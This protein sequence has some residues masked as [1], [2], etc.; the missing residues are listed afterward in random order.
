MQQVLRTKGCRDRVYTV[1]QLP[2]RQFKSSG[3]VRLLSLLRIQY[4]SRCQIFC[5]DISPAVGLEPQIYTQDS[6][7]SR[8][9]RPAE[10]TEFDNNGALLSRAGCAR[11]RYCCR[12]LKGAMLWLS[13]FP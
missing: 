4:V 7:H 13:D 9:Q 12:A 10:Q 8:H 3:G 2:D 6:V 5:R 1:F 11:D